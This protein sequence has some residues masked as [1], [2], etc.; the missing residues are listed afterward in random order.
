MPDQ[1]DSSTPSEQDSTALQ[2]LER[3]IAAAHASVCKA[4]GGALDSALRAGQALL[5]I[6]KRQLIRRGGQ[7]LSFCMGVCGSSRTAR[8]YTYLA[9]NYSLVDS[10]KWQS[11]ATS[12]ATALRLIRKADGTKKSGKPS[13]ELKDSLLSKSIAEWSD[14][15]IADALLRLG[16]S[17]FKN[18]IPEQFRRLLEA[19]AGNQALR[20]TIAAHPNT[21][22]KHLKLAVDND[23]AKTPPVVHSFRASR[24]GFG[25]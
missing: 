24:T 3:I 25:L 12:I 10:A 8:V 23:E 21:K 2:R 15:E 18:V 9:A 20:R 17:R 11:S 22:A 6:K 16:F 14:A 13:T 7:W 1:G 5:E 4:E 19:S